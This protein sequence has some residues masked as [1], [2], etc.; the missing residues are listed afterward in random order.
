MNKVIVLI[1]VLLPLGLLFVLGCGTSDSVSEK[2]IDPMLDVSAYLLPESPEGALNIKAARE[3][4]KDNDAVVVVGRIGGGVNPWVDECAAFM[5]VDC[6]LLAC[7][8]NK[9]VG[10]HVS[11]PTPWDYCCE[12]DKLPNAMAFVQ[13]SDEEGNVIRKDARE[14]FDLKELQTIT[15]RGI[16]KRDDAGN[17]KIIADGLFVN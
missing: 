5:I 15:V 7:S 12:T 1:S 10:A 14:L 4:I 16:A 9:E 11:C 17:L 13:F 8:D 2:S 6:S 3:S